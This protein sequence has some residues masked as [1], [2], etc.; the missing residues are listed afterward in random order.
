MPSIQF[1]D[2]GNYML[3]A[4]INGLSRKYLKPSSLAI[5]W[6]MMSTAKSSQSYDLIENHA[7]DSKMIV[8][9]EL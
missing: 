4:G 5:L 7:A 2:E 8:K 3:T 9:I 6:T 1:H